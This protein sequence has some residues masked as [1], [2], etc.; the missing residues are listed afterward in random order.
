M[1][2]RFNLIKED[3]KVFG[4]D[5]VLATDP[6]S[7]PVSRILVGANDATAET[8]TG[9][10]VNNV[11][12]NFAVQTSQLGDPTPPV[13]PNSGNGYLTKSLV[14]LFCLLLNTVF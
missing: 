10:N 13:A 11:N 9:F 12:A 3:V 6:N 4:D 14:V 8:A 2:G 1:C 5:K 7:I